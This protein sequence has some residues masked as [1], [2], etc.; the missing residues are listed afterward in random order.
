MGLTGNKLFERSVEID[1]LALSPGDVVVL[2]SDGI[3]EAMNT[4]LELFGEDRLQSVV[5]RH[6]D[7]EAGD[8]ERAIL[9]EVR[10]FMGAEPA[11]DDMTLFVL[12]A[13]A[14]GR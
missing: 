12:R 3:T 1:R 4:K 14:P 13:A 6:A 2:Y 9:K 10:E 5:D 7:A 8:I 11:H